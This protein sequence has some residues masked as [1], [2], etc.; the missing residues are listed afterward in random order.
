VRAKQTINI[1]VPAGVETGNRIQMSGRGEVGAGGGPAGDLYVE[2]V[3]KDHS[4]LLRDGDNLHIAITVPFA[5]ATLGTTVKV[6]AL[7]GPLDVT[8]KAGTQS[9]TTVAVKGKGMT[10]LRTTHRGDLIVHVDIETPHKLNKEQ[11]KLLREFSKARGE[12]DGDVTIK[13]HE[14][15][16]FAKFKD[17]FQR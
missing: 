4:Y 1:K 5:A 11:E 8:I 2:I 7:D 15:G 13:G 10:R 9:G 16:L 14:E 17:V 12:K 3:E 6:E